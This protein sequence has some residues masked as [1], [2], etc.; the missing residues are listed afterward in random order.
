[1]L[2]VAEGERAFQVSFGKTEF[3]EVGLRV[4]PPYDKDCFKLVAE[5]GFES[6]AVVIVEDERRFR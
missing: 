1:M 5:P 4:L 3:E 6:I 2:R